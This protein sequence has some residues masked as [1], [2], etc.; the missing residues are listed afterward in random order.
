MMGM[1]TTLNKVKSIFHRGLNNR[2]WL[3]KAKMM[4]KSKNVFMVAP[5][6]E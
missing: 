6:C 1:H 3:I 4:Y 5:H 2:T